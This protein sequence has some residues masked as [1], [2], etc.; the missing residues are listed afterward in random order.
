M[1][2]GVNQAIIAI[3][4]TLALSVVAALINKWLGEVSTGEFVWYIITYSICCI[5]PYK[6]SKRSNPTRWT[7][8][9]FVAA[10]F[11]LMLGGIAS[12]MPKADFVVSIIM[13]PVEF[14]AVFRL[15][16]PEAS[17]WFKES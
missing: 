4:I 6:L 15:F 16:Q 9:I 10:T 13:I 11:V 8:A 2:I 3:W 12:D 17:R 14:F 1:P 7:Y 5:F